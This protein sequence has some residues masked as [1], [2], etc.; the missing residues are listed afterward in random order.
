MKG[1][2]QVKKPDY[3]DKVVYCVIIWAHLRLETLHFFD[4][5]KCSAYIDIVADC[6]T[7]WDGSCTFDNFRFPRSARCLSMTS[8]RCSSSRVT[9]FR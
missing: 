3:R 4:V 8:Y 9:D 6:V 7:S 2:C 5:L 1:A